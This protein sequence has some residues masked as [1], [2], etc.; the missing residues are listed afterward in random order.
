MEPNR[1]PPTNTGIP[2]ATQLPAT[3]N[4]N[5]EESLQIIEEANRRNVANGLSS[6]NGSPQ[7]MLQTIEETNRQS[8]ASGNPQAMLQV[9]EQANRQNV[10]NGQ[11]SS[12]GN[13]QTMPQ[14]TNR[15]P[16]FTNTG[17]PTADHL[18]AMGNG[19]PLEALQAI[20]EAN[21]Q[22]QI[23]N[24]ANGQFSSNGAAQRTL[25]PSPTFPPPENFICITCGAILPK[26]IQT[27]HIQSHIAD[28]LDFLREQES[29][30]ADNRPAPSPSPA[31]SSAPSFAPARPKNK[32]DKS[33]A[34]IDRE[35]RAIANMLTRY[36]NL[37]QLATMKNED[38]ATQ[39][40][41]ATQAFAM[42][43]ETAAL[44]RG[45]EDLLRLSRELK[46][47]WLFGSLRDVGEGEGEGKIDEDAAKVGEI[48]KEKLRADA[49]DGV[50]GAKS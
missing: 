3:G 12:N 36:R 39:E 26:S 15:P 4:G 17:V 40:V 11:S 28:R 9:I 14:V 19:N 31:P 8:V 34:F 47:L 24:I 33:S 2:S 22:R 32:T 23:Q 43:A 13:P 38:G 37:V 45:A 1:P 18:A 6:S 10:A 20:I 7:A 41:A 46:E 44:V 49:E 30:K 27:D 48:L 25:Q 21:R 50:S 5:P 29:E 35:E 16:L 42:E